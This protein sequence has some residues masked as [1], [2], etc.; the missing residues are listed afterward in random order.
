MNHRF[1]IVTAVLA[2]LFAG[3]GEEAGP[4]SPAAPSGP[5]EEKLAYVVYQWSPTVE[6]QGL[7]NGTFKPTFV[8]DDIGAHTQMFDHVSFTRR[9][10]DRAWEVKSQADSHSYD[11]LVRQLSDGKKTRA[12][13]STCWDE[14]SMCLPITTTD[15]FILYTYPGIE[16]DTDLQGKTITKFVFVLERLDFEPYSGLFDGTS[17]DVRW[18][19]DIYGYDG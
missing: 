2:A 10:V 13:I 15:D 7:Y 12:Y 3:C 8:F 9:D 18:R 5:V 19:V 11:H 14:M 6:R 17:V 16:L 1:I 4:V